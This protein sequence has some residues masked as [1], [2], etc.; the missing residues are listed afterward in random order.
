MLKNVETPAPK[1][2]IK[3]NAAALTISVTVKSCKIIEMSISA[4]YQNPH[5]YANPQAVKYVVSNIVVGTSN[6]I[7]KAFY[8][9][10]VIFT[11]EIFRC[12][13]R[14]N[15]MFL[16]HENVA[17]LISKLVHIIHTHPNKPRTPTNLTAALHAA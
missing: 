6:L 14:R 1:K 7:I 3:D 5:I 11:V 13:P 4:L 10:I 17:M 15:V 2:I 16:Q 9:C 12:L 8:N